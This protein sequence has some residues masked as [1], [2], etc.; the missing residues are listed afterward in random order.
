MPFCY[1]K[2]NKKEIDVSFLCVCPV[3]DN[4]FRH[5]IVKVAGDSLAHGKLTPGFHFRLSGNQI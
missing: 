5:S 1:C 4:E 3:I 2:K